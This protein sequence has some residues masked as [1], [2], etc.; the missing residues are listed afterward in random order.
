ELQVTQ[1]LK[2][3]AAGRMEAVNVAGTSSAFPGDFLGGGLDPVESGRTRNF[4]PRSVS[5]GV[6]HDLPWNM[7][8]SLTGQYVERA[9]R[10]PEL[11]SRGAHDAPGTFEIGNPDLKPEVAKTAEIGLKRATGRLRFE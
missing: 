9:P 7:V 4:A 5:L 11:F 1:L 3:Q 10:A 8:A 2:L 6:L